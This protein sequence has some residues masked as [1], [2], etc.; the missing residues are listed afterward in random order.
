MKFTKEE[1]LEIGR[2]IYDGELSKYAAVS[3]Y[4]IS[5]C[6]ARDY[7][8]LYRD[9]NGLPPRSSRTKRMPKD[10]EPSRT[11]TPKDIA[12]MSREE[13]IEAL[14]AARASEARLKQ[15]LSRAIKML[16]HS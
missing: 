14:A 15:K 4:D 2:R 9:T 12:A 6:C 8:R 3:K 10:T 1:R 7:M 16:A 13:L 11:E 5:I